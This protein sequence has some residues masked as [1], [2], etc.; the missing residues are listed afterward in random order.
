M[1]GSWRWNAAFG[2][3]GAALTFLFSLANNPFG[4]TILRTLL[5]F[6]AFGLMAFAVRFVLGWLLIPPAQ[7]FQAELPEE[8]RG[9]V[10]D[11]RTPDDDRLLSEML[12]E[13]WSDGKEAGVAGF[14]PLQ[15]KRLVSLDDP[16]P[17]QVVQ[18][19]RRLNDE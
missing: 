13:Q 12:K 18:A 10:L 14:Q 9:S 3:F 5:G 4:T 7:P 2:G 11:L 17:E 19:I 1:I 16:D 6:A 15:P 8:E